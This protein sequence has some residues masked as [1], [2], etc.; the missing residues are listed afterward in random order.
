MTRPLAI[1]GV[2]TAL[3][4][5]LA[6]G[7][8]SANSASTELQR[9]HAGALDVVLLSDH[10]VLRQGKDTSVLE[11]RHADGSLADVGIVKANATMAMAGMGAMIGAVDVQPSDT[12]G[13]YRMTSDLSMVGSWRFILEW[14]GAGTG[15]ASLSASAR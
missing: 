6:C 2:A 7:G 12:K 13:R 3:L 11:F 9:I 1:A 15:S 5:T 10:G 8:Q 14:D 4:V